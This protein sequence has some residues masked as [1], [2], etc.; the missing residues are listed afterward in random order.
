MNKGK[1]SCRAALGLG[2]SNWGLYFLHDVHSFARSHTPFHMAILTEYSAPD[3]MLE[4]WI[5]CVY[6]SQNG[7]YRS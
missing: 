4:T 6:T 1:P 7:S 2:S 3:F 5:N